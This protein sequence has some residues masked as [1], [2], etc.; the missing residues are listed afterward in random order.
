M[1][2]GSLSQ[3]VKG[4]RFVVTA[5]CRPPRGADASRLKSCAAS[6]GSLVDAVYAPESEDGARMASLAACVHLA[7]AG[8]EPILALLTRDLNRIAL[9][10]TLIGAASLGVKNILCIAGRHQTL[11]TSK[12][13]KGVFDLD[14]VQLLSVANETRRSGT[15]ADGQT[16]DSPLDLLL[17][18]EVNPFSDPME[19]QVIALEKA[20]SAGAD[21]IITQPVFNVP[22]LESWMG[23]VRDKGLQERTC[24]IA[25]VVPAATPQ[26]AASLAE[27]YKHLDIPHDVFERLNTAGDRRSASTHMA[28]ETIGKI[29]QIEGIRGIHLMTGSDFELAKNVLSSSGIARSE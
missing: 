27:S 18:T 6:L 25:S 4:S 16:L 20:I 10:S 22:K 11:T 3:A 12:S 14:A 13:A 23:M 2:N 26:D 5:D 1:A 8:A 9:Q 24:I 19:L 29:K 17:G 15:L 21:F 28:V 7:A